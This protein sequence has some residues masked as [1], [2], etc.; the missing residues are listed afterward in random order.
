MGTYL[1]IQGDPEEVSAT[2]A[3]LRAM[4]E[5]LRARTQEIRGEISAVHAERPWGSDKYGAAFEGSYFQVP[6]GCE[7]PLPTMVDDGMA[8]AGD[9]LT[10]IG[11]TTVRAMTGY[12][13]ADEAG[14]NDIDTVV[15]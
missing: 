3:G 14:A 1:D 10:V 12:R 15:P 2:G 11:D 9:R 8:R 13:G 5:T 6:A 7:E 4:G